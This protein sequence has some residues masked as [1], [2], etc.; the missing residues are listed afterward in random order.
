MSYHLHQLLEDMTD[1]YYEA[2][3]EGVV[4]SINS[5]LQEL[6]GVTAQDAVGR[7]CSEALCASDCEPDCPLKW[8]VENEKNV[9][10]FSSEIPLG[11]MV[12]GDTNLQVDFGFTSPLP[13]T[14]KLIFGKVPPDSLV[15][16]EPA[17]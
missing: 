10:A 11:G 1:G 3:P 8:A 14:V 4:T 16:H 9:I 17:V 15:T 13:A 2:T 6:L 7:K 5:K 12:G